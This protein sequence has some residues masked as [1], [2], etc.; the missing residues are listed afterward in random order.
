MFMSA[1]A[2]K[3]FEELYD[4]HPSEVQGLKFLSIARSTDSLVGT[5]DG[6][7]IDLGQTEDD[8]RW[9]TVDED[10]GVMVSWTS[11]SDAR[12]GASFPELWSTEGAEA[13]KPSTE[14]AQES[15]DA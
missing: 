11:L 3:R 4:K 6:S 12:Y 13:P 7:K 5:Y 1:K 14:G 8:Y 2:I 15:V 9:L 10:A